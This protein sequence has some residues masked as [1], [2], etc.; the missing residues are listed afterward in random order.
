MKR[1]RLKVLLAAIGVVLAL[2]ALGVA[3][4]GISR[5]RFAERW[6]LVQM[7]MSRGQVESLLGTPANIYPSA[8]SAESDSILGSIFLSYVLDLWY[9]K[10]AYGR[11]RLLATCPQFPFVGPALDGFLKPEDDDYVVYFSAHGKV[12]KKVQPYPRSGTH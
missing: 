3:F 1:V 9:E 4:V 5:H 7:G 12:V 8:Q 10:W 6:Q 11:R 2:I